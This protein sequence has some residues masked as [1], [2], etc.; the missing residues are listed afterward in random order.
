M[1]EIVKNYRDN[2]VLRQSFDGLAG[3]TFGLTFE[4]WYRNGYWSDKYIPPG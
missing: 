3:R 1:L 4:D 2:A